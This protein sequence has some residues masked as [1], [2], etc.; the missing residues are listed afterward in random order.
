MASM[1]FVINDT[2]TG[3]AT[4]AVQITITE[5]PDGTVTFSIVQLVGAGAYLGDLRGFFFDVADETLINTLSTT[6]NPLLTE[7]AQGND[8]ITNLGDGANM[9]GLVGDSGGYDVGVEIG[10]S[11]IGTNGNDVRNFSFTL[12]SSARDL[13]L[14]DFAN[15][16]F[17]I[18][19]TSIGQDV[20]GDGTIDTSR[21]G[22]AKVGETTFALVALSPDCATVAEDTTAFGNILTNDTA[23]ALD[24]L[25]VQSWDGGALGTPIEI[26]GGQGAT[27]TL[28]ADGTWS[29]DAPAADALAAGETVTQTFTVTI[30]QT[31]YAD[32]AHTIPDGTYTTTETFTVK[33][34]GTN[35]APILNATAS[36][37]LNSVNE[38]APAPVGAV[39]TL[40]SNLV[41]LDS[42]AGG[43]DNVSDVDTGAV[44]GIAVIDANA[45]SG[46]WWYSIDGGGSWLLLGSVLPSSAV[47]LDGSALLFFQP[48]SNFNGTIAD[49]LTIRAWDQAS[50]TNGTT[51]VDTTT[52]GGTTAFSTVFDTVSTTVNAVNDA[53]A[54]TDT[55]VSTNEDTPRVFAA[56]DF[57]FSDTFDG[58]SLAAVKISSLPVAGTL[59]YAGTAITAAQVTAGF[60]VLVADLGLLT[61][62][63]AANANGTSYASFTFQVRDDGGTAN[64]GVDTDQSANTMTIDVTSVND[65][66]VLT[67]D[68]TGAVT[69]DATN[70]NLT[71]SG[72]LSFTDADATDTH[73]VSKS[74]N[75]DAV[76][77][78]GTL[79]AGQITA[80]TSGFSVDN[81][82]WD[83]TVANA[84][85]QFL[86]KGETI[87]FSFDV[88]A[89][90]DSGAANDF[91]TELVTLTLTGTNDAP[92]VVTDRLVI[93]SVTTAVFS[94]AALLGN[95]TDADGEGLHITGVFGAAGVTATYD[96]TTQTI[97]VITSGAMG[98]DT[99]SFS[100][101]VSDGITTS[102]GAVTIDVVNANPGFDLSTYSYQAS[103][104]DLGA[105]GDTGTGSGGFDTLLGGAGD[106]TLIGGANDDRLIGGAGIDAINGGAGN[107]VIIVNAVVGTSSDSIRVAPAGDA[108]DTGQDTI[109]G[110][111]LSNDTLRVVATSVSS[112]VHGTSTA[113]G[114]AGA[115]N[116]GLVTSFTTSTGLVDLN[117]DGDFADAGDIAV[118]FST[119]SV[120][121][122]ETNFEARLQYNL[123]GTGGADTITT[124]D[125]DDTIAGGAGIDVLNGGAGDDQLSGGAGGDTLIG[126]D[127]TDSIDTGAANDN[128]QDI[129]RFGATT[130][131][132][133]LVFN[134]D[135]T[136][137]LAQADR[138]EFT[139]ALNTAYDDKT[140]DDNFQFASDNDTDNDNQTANLT[141]TFEALFLDGLNSEGVSN[142]DLDDATAVAAEFSAEFAIT[143]GIG[144]D[145]LLVINDTDGN[146]FALWQFVEDTGAAG[147]AGE[148]SAGELSLIGF[149]SGNGTVLT[150]NLDLI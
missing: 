11:G 7:L 67:V 87:T 141:L 140:L 73:T 111:D 69:E 36:P 123:T 18:R 43:L 55:T 38:D 79:S 61:F 103:Y 3:G 34:V 14:A 66:P 86:G 51:G 132:G 85:L 24:V 25:T 149:F 117:N 56:A 116:T 107:D 99:G 148:I 32:A 52:N 35:D 6:A 114:T 142:A 92:V 13:T 118:T 100:Y 1:T 47:L 77:S 131:F 146:S 133:D 124:G 98:V 96:A 65:A 74:F 137:T 26:T 2:S 10:T 110:F 50:G 29:I 150:G 9:N 120:T 145:A 84:A 40:V 108:N 112:F 60:E 91:D 28:K 75:N 143:A 81:N 136:G 122:T 46:T 130:E 63:P 41:D 37:V 76:W 93:S 19:I 147:G 62:E 126:G 78:A 109:T 121:L 16:T 58:N 45:A 44:T 49:A 129:I 4:P 113:I 59:K 21:T 139:G 48:S 88:V 53:P 39:G 115:N 134:F 144:E 94:A 95:D 8:S 70:P 90:D 42:L 15:V 106:D 12:D 33:I 119:P 72:T 128:L 30:L 5:N 71:D 57:G 138:V 102:T 64:G 31:H 125:L 135:A 82:S 97:T 105:G 68:A 104:L 89:T 83:Y 17:G 27:V 127:G 54:G 22:S 23:T 80:I 20:N 101:T